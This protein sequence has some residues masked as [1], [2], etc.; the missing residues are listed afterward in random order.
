ML[1]KHGIYSTAIAIMAGMVYYRFTGRDYSW[2]ISQCVCTG[3]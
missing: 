3:C 1:F 2:I